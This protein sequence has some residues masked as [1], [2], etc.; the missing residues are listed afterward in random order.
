MGDGVVHVFYID[1]YESGGYSFE[2]T[3]SDQFNVAAAIRYR[4]VRDV[5][6]CAYLA[7][8]RESY[9]G[10]LARFER[11]FIDGKEPHKHP[12]RDITEEDVR[13]LLGLSE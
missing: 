2:V 7:C 10:T 11:L 3:D 8:N 9:I 6:D 12:L 5:P 13:Q 1:D 4:W